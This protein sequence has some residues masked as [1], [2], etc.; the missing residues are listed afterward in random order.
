LSS[1]VSLK[2]TVCA[3][4]IANKNEKQKKLQKTRC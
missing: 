1:S 3:D 2:L 4:T